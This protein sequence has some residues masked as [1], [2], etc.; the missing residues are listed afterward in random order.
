[1]IKITSIRI[2]KLHKGS[3]S[4]VLGT[5]SVGFDN[6]LVVHNIKLVQKDGKRIVCFPSRKVKKFNMEGGEYTERYEY[7]DIVH[8]SN[9]EFRDYIEEEIFKVYD[10]EVSTDGKNN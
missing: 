9:K 3:G 10:M 4:N 5:A 1:M 2:K 7:A 6:C 8:P